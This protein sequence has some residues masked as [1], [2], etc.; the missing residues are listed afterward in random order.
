M[1]FVVV[2]LLGILVFGR[3]RLFRPPLRSEFGLFSPSDN[4]IYMQLF[5]NT[6]FN[7][8]FVFLHCFT[9]SFFVFFFPLFI[10]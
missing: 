6:H 10:S 3:V 9:L 4:K 1:H 2:S 5:N 7:K 8:D